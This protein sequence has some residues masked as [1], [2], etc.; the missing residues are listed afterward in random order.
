MAIA[1][2]F[3]KEPAIVFFDEPTAG[4]DV[5]TEQLLVASIKKLRA[6]ATIILAAHQYESIRFAD[7]I[8]IVED[9]QIV[10]SGTPVT[11]KNHPYFKK[12]AEGR[13]TACNN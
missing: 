13:N 7:V 1:S 3:L 11:L 2:T 8:Y 5:V 12:I 6:N 4:L 10:S 9:G